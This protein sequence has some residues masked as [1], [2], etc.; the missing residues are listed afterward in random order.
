MKKYLE[1]DTKQ[2]KQLVCIDT[3]MYLEYDANDPDAKVYVHLTGG[4]HRMV[5]AGQK[6]KTDTDGIVKYIQEAMEDA[7]TS[8]WLKVSHP[9]VLPDVMIVNGTSI[10]ELKMELLP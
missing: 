10:E 5:I 6:L 2:G 9:L 1:I 3:W 4:T 7:Y 8:S